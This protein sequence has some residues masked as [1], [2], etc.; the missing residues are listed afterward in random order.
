MSAR[1]SA[2]LM[3]AIVAPTACGWHALLAPYRAG[4]SIASP[5]L[6]R[7]DVALIAERQGQLLRQ[8]LQAKLQRGEQRPPDFVLQASYSVTREGIAIT[9][10]TSLT[11]LRLIGTADY[12]LRSVSTGAPTCAAG[13][14]RQ[15]DG[16]D[17]QN[18]QFF[19]ADLEAET[20]ERRLA[21][22]VAT[23]IVTRLA[24]AAR[25]PSGMPCEVR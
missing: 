14:V 6:D 5:L 4:A 25:A 22:A 24:V 11:R 23:Q 20:V 19:A 12:V 17:V 7:V 8:A 2:A 21:E 10:E 15:V 3:L 13:T 16:L 18:Q 9:Q 1:R